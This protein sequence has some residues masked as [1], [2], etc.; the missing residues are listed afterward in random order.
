[1]NREACF[2]VPF[3][4]KAI[5]CCLLKFWMGISTMHMIRVEAQSWSNMLL[6]SEISFLSICQMMGI[7]HH[8]LWVRLTQLRARS[9]HY[10]QDLAIP[11]VSY[12]G[13]P[14]SL[15]HWAFPVN[16]GF[17]PIPPIPFCIMPFTLKTAML[18]VRL[19]FFLIQFGS[20]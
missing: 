1:M 6:M 18:E 3:H 13:I 15:C 12:H 11:F 5:L 17:A 19:I 16:L 2:S 8:M 14:A 9:V 4:L 7:I 10:L 20:W